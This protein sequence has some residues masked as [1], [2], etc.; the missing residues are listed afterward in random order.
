MILRKLFPF[1]EVLVISQ[2]GENVR[3]MKLFLSIEAEH[4]KSQKIIMTEY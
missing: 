2:N 1:I 3:L 4:L